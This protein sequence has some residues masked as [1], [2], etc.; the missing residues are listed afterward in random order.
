MGH[1]VSSEQEALL[2]E[3][4]AEILESS[5]TAPV[6]LATKARKVAKEIRQSAADAIA[7]GRAP[8]AFQGKQ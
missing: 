4:L 7:E 6:P 1:S 8:S 2:F 3:V 5:Y